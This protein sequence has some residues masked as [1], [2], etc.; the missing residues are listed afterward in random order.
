MYARTHA[1]MRSYMHTY[2][3]ICM[4]HT[5]T[6]TQTVKHIRTCTHIHKYIDDVYIRTY[7]LNL[8]S[9]LSDPTHRNSKDLGMAPA[10]GLQPPNLTSPQAGKRK[11]KQGQ[12][13]A[14]G[15]V[16]PEEVGTGS[17]MLTSRDLL[18]ATTLKLVSSSMCD[19]RPASH[20]TNQSNLG[21]L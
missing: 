5:H 16:Q 13:L 7:H 3:H 10:H 11:E 19:T 2:T 12:L 18:T 21:F 6:Y 9:A 20:S 17:K 15:R 1:H 8:C 4:H 14:C